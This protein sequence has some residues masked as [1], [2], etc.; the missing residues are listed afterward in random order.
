[1]QKL[2]KIEDFKQ[3]KHFTHFQKNI[4]NITNRTKNCWQTIMRQKKCYGEIFKYQG[5]EKLLTKYH[6]SK[7]GK[8]ADNVSCPKKSNTTDKVSC[9]KNIY[10]RR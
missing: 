6:E 10:N 7:K 3:Y 1:M 4:T 2:L 5:K 9:V 8:T